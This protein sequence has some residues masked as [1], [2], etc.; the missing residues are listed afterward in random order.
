[1]V[2]ATHEPVLIRAAEREVP[3]AG[4]GAPAQRGAWGRISR[5]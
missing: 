4:L 3:M 1:V 2:C 5:P